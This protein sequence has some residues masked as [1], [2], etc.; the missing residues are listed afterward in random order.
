MKLKGLNGRLDPFSFIS[1]CC[2][3]AKTGKQS[4]KLPTSRLDKVNNPTE[5]PSEPSNQAI[6]ESNM[7]VFKLRLASF[8][9]MLF[10]IREYEDSTTPPKLLSGILLD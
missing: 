4:K 5:Q 6:G 10:V 1:S 3:T 8:S 2:R 9:N 7:R